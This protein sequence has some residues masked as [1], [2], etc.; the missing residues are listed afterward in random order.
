MEE[1]YYP[2]NR[3]QGETAVSTL[4]DT[5]YELEGYPLAEDEW[6]YEEEVVYEEEWVYADA[7][8]LAY[9]EFVYQPDGKQSVVRPQWLIMPA[10][11][12]T[13]MLLIFLGQSI[14]YTGE[15]VTGGKTAVISENTA[16]I[17]GLSDSFISPYDE[18]VLTQGLHGYSYGH[19]AIDIAAGAGATIKAPIDGVIT[20]L[21]TDQYSNPT[22]V[23]ENGRYKVTFLHGNYTAVLGQQFKQGDA[24]GTEGNNGYTMD[25]A[26][27]LCYGRPGCGYHTHLNVFD[28]QLG[29]NVNPLDLIS[30]EQ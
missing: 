17:G 30:N 21:Y 3:I 22:L 11:L 9:E 12:L 6:A 29:Q 14:T 25:G 26:G 15:P 10:V 18:Y 8:H 2:V 24:I 5:D 20:E 7:P 13:V 23:I 19:M 4:H 1:E 16:S 28:K 27:N